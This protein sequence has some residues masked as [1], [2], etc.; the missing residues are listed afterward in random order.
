MAVAQNVQ[1]IK[2]KAVAVGESY[3]QIMYKT[4]CS[5]E[6]CSPNDNGLFTLT[7]CNSDCDFSYRDQWVVQDSMQVFT[8]RNCNNIA[9]PKKS[10]LEAK[11]S[12]IRK[13][14]SVNGPYEKYHCG[15]KV[16]RSSDVTQGMKKVWP[17]F[18]FFL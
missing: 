1:I 7:L 13:S 17:Y 14:Y 10:P 2:Q 11:T 9:N 8:L 18:P 6:H 15:E 5:N 4:K 12:R 16:I 3:V